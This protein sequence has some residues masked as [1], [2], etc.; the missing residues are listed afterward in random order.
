[1]SNLGQ[2]ADMIA[3]LVIA[4]LAWISS[5]VGPDG[6]AGS[7]APASAATFGQDQ[8]G[9]IMRWAQQDDEPPIEQVGEGTGGDV[10]TLDEAAPPVEEGDANGDVE[11]LDQGPP[12]A[13]QE[14]VE[15]LDEG[16]PAAAQENV[17]LLDQ[18]PP[19]APAAESTA[20][21]NVATEPV[22]T[23]VAP[24]ATNGPIVPEGFGTGSVQVATGAGGFPVGLEDCHVG[25]VTGRAFV[26]ID[27]GEGGGSSF[28]GHA[29]SFEEFPFVLD[30]SFPFDRESVFA[31]RGEDQSADNVV[32]MVSNASGAT[33][34]DSA[35]APEIRTSGAS[36]VSLEQRAR[37]KKPRVEAKS[38]RAKHGRDSR[39]GRTGQ[40]TSSESQDGGNQASAGSKQDA[41]QRGQDGNRLSSTDNDG[42]KAKN[43]KHAKN[44]GGK[45][46]ENSRTAS[47]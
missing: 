5:L 42:K 23:F 37:D 44:R 13:A 26:G 32:T 46:S 2:I 20:P 10:E 31:D 38:G 28:V 27:C 15:L 33:R 12:A 24:A 18:G 25:A 8:L 45:K 16:P 21:S 39:R 36:S 6:P 30:Q 47:E 29:P 3:T 35:A 9:S 40:V 41:K 4:S 1:M 7:P 43:P 14:D 19:A 11:L 17:E 22:V 34:N